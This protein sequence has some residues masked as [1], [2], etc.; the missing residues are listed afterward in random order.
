[1]DQVLIPPSL[2]AEVTQSYTEGHGTR[3]LIPKALQAEVIQSLHAAHQGLSSMNERQ[4]PQF[5]GQ[6]YPLIFRKLKICAQAV[7]E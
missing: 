3:V 7:T 5:I 1:M 2:R 4:K 6:E